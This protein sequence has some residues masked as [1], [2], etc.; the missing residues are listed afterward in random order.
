MN[1][2]DGDPAIRFAL[3][4][5]RASD[6]PVFEALFALDRRLAATLSDVRGL[7]G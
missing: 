2:L 5:A 1:D 6:S 7:P 4:Y 3:A